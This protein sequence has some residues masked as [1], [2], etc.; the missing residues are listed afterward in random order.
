MDTK[1]IEALEEKTRLIVDAL[2]KLECEAKRQKDMADSLAKGRDAIVGLAS[3]LRLVAKRLAGVVDMVN[4]STL[5]K[6]VSHLIEIESSCAW[7]HECAVASAGREAEIM[8]RL[9]SLEE[10]TSRLDKNMQK[11]ADTSADRE[12]DI[13]KRLAALE[14]VV[15]RIDRNTQKG[16]LK[17]RE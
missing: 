14:D 17:E 3:E 5:G 8:K 11:S 2:S 10:M 4:E 13:L 15:G 9:D 16:F 7:L 12:E 1:E 6:D